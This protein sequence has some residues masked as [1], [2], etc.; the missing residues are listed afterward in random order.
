[1]GHQLL[2]ALTGHGGHPASRVKGARGKRGGCP[3]PGLQPP[4]AGDWRASVG[5]PARWGVPSARLPD[6][7][8]CRVYEKRL[9]QG[10]EAKGDVAAVPGCLRGVTEEKEP[11]SSQ[12]CAVEI[13]TP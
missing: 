10:E 13:S 8:K 5:L 12:R 6:M 4:P 9:L 2:T 7:C 1:M 3:Q 11:D